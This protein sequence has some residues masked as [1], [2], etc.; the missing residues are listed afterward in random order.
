[1]EIAPDRLAQCARAERSALRLLKQHDLREMLAAVQELH[2]CR[3]DEFAFQAMTILLKLVPGQGASFNRLKMNPVM[4]LCQG[5]PKKALE[6][7]TAVSRQNFIRFQDQHPFVTL[8]RETGG[9]APVRTTDVIP[10][11]QFER[12]P[13]YNEYYRRFDSRFQIEFTLPAPRDVCLCMVLDR[14]DRD[15]TERDR[16]VLTLLQPHVAQAYQTAQLQLRNVALF[17][18]LN[19]DPS[20][21]P[22]MALGLTARQAEVLYWVTKGKTNPEI[23]TILGASHHTIHRHVNAILARVGVENRAAAMLRAIEVL[24]ISLRVSG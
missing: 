16:A 22:L 14:A 11:R 20:P 12:L 18:G 9:F 1:M 13:I 21:E 10:L 19:G 17:S 3:P 2:C 7:L 8:F 23:G 15:F 4:L 6:P 5:Y 24:G